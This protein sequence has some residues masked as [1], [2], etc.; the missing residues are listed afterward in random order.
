MYILRIHVLDLFP[1]F[2]HA[3]PD[4]SCNANLGDMP[5]PG[6]H[7]LGIGVNPNGF[8][9]GVWSDVAKPNFF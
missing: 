2:L 7:L 5:Q 8:P 9:Q 3:V 6:V 4:R 1:M